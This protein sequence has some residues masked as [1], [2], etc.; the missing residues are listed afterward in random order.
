MLY[1]VYSPV[2]QS[3][4][5]TACESKSTTQAKK[6]L[7]YSTAGLWIRI[8]LIRIRIQH[9]YSIRI[10]IQAETELLKTISLSNFVEIKI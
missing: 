1:V 5:C 9:F 7:K 4:T 6:H 8:D 2:P 3:D 10:R